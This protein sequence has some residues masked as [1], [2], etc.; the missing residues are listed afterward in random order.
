MAYMSQEKK[1]TLAPAIKAVL[2]KFDMKGSISVNNHSTLVVTLSSGALKFKEY[3]G[4]ES[5]QCV[6]TYHIE[7]NTEFTKKEKEF[8]MELKSAMMNGN[9][10]R[11][12]IMTDL[13]DVGWYIDINIGRWNKAYQPA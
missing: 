6:N 2:K 5:Y 13:F 11:S 10:D 9:H 7:H 8:L 3:L 12:D 1:A 4:E